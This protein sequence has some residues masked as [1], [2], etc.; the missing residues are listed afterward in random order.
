VNRPFVIISLVFLVFSNCLLAQQISQTP[1]SHEEIAFR[2]NQGQFEGDFSHAIYTPRYAAYLNADGF[3]IGMSPIEALKA[4]HDSAHAYSEVMP[5]VPVFGFSWKFI[6]HNADASA[7]GEQSKT[8]VRNYFFGSQENWV[9]GLHDVEQVR[10]ANIYSGI[11]VLYKMHPKRHLEYDFIVEAGADPSQIRWELSGVEA[12][13]KGDEIIYTTPYGLVK[14]IIPEAYQVIAGKKIAVDVSF[15]KVEE[16]FGFEI[17]EYDENYEL[18]ID[19]LLIGATLTGSTGDNNYGHGAAYDQEGNIFSFGIGFGPGLPTTDGAIQENYEG[20]FGVN[21]VINKFSPDATEQLYATYL[22]KDD[23]YPNSASANLFGELV[24]FGSTNDLD[25]PTTAGCYQESSGGGSDIF[26]SRIS[27][28]GTELL[29]STYLGGSGQDG[30]NPINVFTYD[31]RRGEVSLDLEGNVYLASATSSDDF[32]TGGGAFSNTLN[33][34]SDGIGA[35]LSADLSVVFWSTYIGGSGD[36]ALLNVRIAENGNVVFSGS[37]NSSDYPTTAGVYQEEDPGGANDP[38]ATL[39]TLSADGSDLLYSTYV[40]TDQDEQGYFMDLDNDDNVWIYGRTRGGDVWPLTDDVFTTENKELFITKFNPELSDI[41][42]STAIGGLEGFNG[43]GGVPLA[44]LVDRCDR[45][46]ISACRA[47]EELPTTDDA[48]FT[49]GEGQFYLAAFIDDLDSLAFGTYYTNDHVDGGTSRFDKSGI[50]YQGVCSGGG[51]N[52]SD[53]AFAPNQ[54]TSWDVG[55]FKIDFQL[56]GVNAA[57]SAPSELD[58]CAPHEISFSNFSV[59]D[60][61]EWDFGDGSTSDE[62]EPVHVFQDPGIYTVS[63]IASDSLSCNLADTV[64]LT[65]DIFSPEDFLPSFESEIDCET[66]TVTFFNTTGGDEFLDFYWIINGDTLYTSYNASHQFANLDGMNTVGLYAVDEGCSLDETVEQELTGLGDVIAEIGN[67][68]ETECGLTIELENNSSNALSYSWDFGDGNTSSQPAPTHTFGEYGTYT[69]SL[70]AGNPSTCN[71][72]D[73]VSTTIEFIEPPVIDGTM[74]LNQTG[75]C[76]ELILE[77]ELDNTSGMTSYTW[78]VNGDEAGSEADFVY[79]GE[80]EGL[81]TVEA[82]IVPNGCN[83]P[84]TISDTITMVSELPL[85]FGPDR[86]IC[87]YENSVLLENGYELENASYE[88]QPGGETSPQLSVTEPGVY[89]VSVTTGLCSDSRSIEIG[90]G[91]DQTSS[92]DIEICEGVGEIIS[93]PVNSLEF[94][95]ENGL[96]GN[97]ITVTR[98]GTYNYSY[99]DL[100]GCEQVGQYIVDGIEPEPLVFIPNSFTPNGDGINDIFKISSG[101]SELDDY[102]FTIHNR[103]GELIFRTTDPDQGWNGAKSGSDFFV[104]AGTYTYYVKYSGICQSETIDKFGTI[105]LIR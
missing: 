48:F 18:V 56:S 50:V 36:D 103:W 95:W 74:T 76:G 67:T 7:E 15:I 41:L 78:F 49:S 83:N 58:G 61:F 22:G 26:I 54:N 88:W 2:P 60:T 1:H 80:F 91:T 90:L 8:I 6:G 44:F 92:F 72:E 29:A 59:G 77:G 93:V 13:I 47:V 62:F 4:H 75:V 98:G 70:T 82:E 87:H 38:D 100:G 52:T 21:A 64:S 24:V 16:G 31:L 104:P 99:I 68:Y 101:E 20:D 73:V 43:A 23:T 65:I 37:T 33:G 89:V 57:F 96:T 105:N 84:F 10:R 94:N 39:S 27:A 86:D 97:T 53:D 25:F 9:T 46:Y 28:D 19:P 85:D 40:G 32:P 3:T 71:G 5:A 51:F 102:E 63:M 17:A 55:V 66:S 30:T 12:D 69:I 79:D 81:Y 11:D 14:E 34:L 42:A 45:V 35:K